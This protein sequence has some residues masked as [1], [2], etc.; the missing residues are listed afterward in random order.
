[1]LSRFRLSTQ[2][3]LG[4]HTSQPSADEHHDSKGI[5]EQRISDQMCQHT[6]QQR[7]ILDKDA[8]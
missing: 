1:M 4:K 5:S 8:C 6:T 2:E 3:L 7:E